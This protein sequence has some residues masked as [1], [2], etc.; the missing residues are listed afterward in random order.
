[1]TFITYDSTLECF[2]SILMCLRQWCDLKFNL[3]CYCIHIISY[4][5]VKLLSLWLVVLSYESM[6]TTF[7]IIVLST[8]KKLESISKL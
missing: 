8:K 6:F 2:I 1:M 5:S 7:S 4:N 3:S